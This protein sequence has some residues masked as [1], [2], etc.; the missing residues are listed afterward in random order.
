MLIGSL[1]PASTSVL[2]TAL[3]SYNE[4]ATGPVIVIKRYG[5]EKPAHYRY[6]GHPAPRFYF[7]VFNNIPGIVSMKQPHHSTVSSGLWFGNSQ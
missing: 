1:S 6:A 3:T 4:G 7:I 5:H 2:I